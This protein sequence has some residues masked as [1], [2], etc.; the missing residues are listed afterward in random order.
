MRLRAR[1]VCGPLGLFKVFFEFFVGEIVLV[2]VIIFV[3]GGGLG[4]S[5]RGCGFR[6][7]SFCG[8][9]FMGGRFAGRRCV[10][11][12]RLLFAGFISIRGV[13]RGFL[14][15]AAGKGFHGA[16]F[17][18]DAGE[19]VDDAGAGELGGVFDV[20]EG[21]AGAFEELL[22]IFGAGARG[23]VGF[24]GLF[25]F[26]FNGA[27][28]AKG[29]FITEDEVDGFVFDEAV[30]G[31]AVLEAD[32]VAEEG[33]EGDA[34]DDV[35]ALAEEVVQELEAGFFGTDH[36]VF[37]GAVAAAIDGVAGAAADA[38][39][40]EHGHQKERQRR[41]N[42]DGDEDFVRAEVFFDERFHD[43]LLRPVAMLARGQGYCLWL[44]RILFPA[45]VI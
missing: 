32:F 8:L 45:T 43:D 36:E 12:V 14:A 30:G 44:Y 15:T 37:A 19:L 5:S 25:V 11:A 35:E 20:D 6:G 40:G 9:G 28:G 29:A 26:E 10:E 38:D 33:R 16:G 7:L 34:G 42:G 22:H 31:A 41:E 27:D 3:S 4:G 13:G 23:F 18:D 17:V 24:F 1:G 21:D 2:V 39:T